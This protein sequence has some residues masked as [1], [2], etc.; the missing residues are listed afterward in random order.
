MFVF[1]YIL[2]LLLFFSSTTTHLLIVCHGAL[3]GAVRG[4]DFEV[5]DA[6]MT[7][8]DGIERGV[9]QV[10][11]SAITAAPALVAGVGVMT[12]ARV[13]DHHGDA[14]LSRF[15][16]SAPRAEIGP[17]LA[18]RLTVDAHDLVAL[19]ALIREAPVVTA[20][21]VPGSTVSGD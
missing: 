21:R 9:R 17:L 4:S 10:E 1:S 13:G 15:L 14:F 7:H 8:R 12:R 16:A 5:H 6:A 2:L 18:A 20:V 3:L 11:V 19:S